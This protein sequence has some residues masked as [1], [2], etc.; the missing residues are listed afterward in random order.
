MPLARCRLW[1][2]DDDLAAHLHCVAADGE[3][4]LLEVDVEPRD[5]RAEVLKLRDVGEPTDAQLTMLRDLYVLATTSRPTGDS[6]PRPD[7][8]IRTA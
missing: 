2:A 8:S 4:G 7:V 1:S 3:G 6:S 5:A